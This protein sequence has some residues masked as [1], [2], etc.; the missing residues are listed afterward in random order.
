MPKSRGL[1]I[2]P[3]DSQRESLPSPLVLFLRP[4]PGPPTGTRLIYT[5]PCGALASAAGGGAK[6]DTSAAGGRGGGIP[7]P[8]TAWP[9]WEEPRLVTPKCPPGLSPHGER[10]PQAGNRGV[11]MPMKMEGARET[12]AAPLFAALIPGSFSRKEEVNELTSKAKV[13]EQHGR[14]GWGAA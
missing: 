8:Q 3:P 14:L 5:P 1:K 6:W 2:Q 4:E 9:L 7:A 10:W 11:L 13:T 12:Q